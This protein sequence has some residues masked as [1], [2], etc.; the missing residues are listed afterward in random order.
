MHD[1]P[2]EVERL[3]RDMLIALTPEERLRMASRMYD[4]A[5]KPIRAA[6]LRENPGLNE[7][8]LRAQLF[9][10]MYGGDFSHD[11]IRKIIQKLP[12]MELE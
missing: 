4:T 8:Q 11:E 3:Y 9:L 5:R 7:A 1:T 2:P 12:N 6:I 10:K